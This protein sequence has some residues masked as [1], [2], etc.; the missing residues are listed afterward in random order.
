MLLADGMA[1]VAEQN[2]GTTPVS[3]RCCRAFYHC[4]YR[5]SF[6][7]LNLRTTLKTKTHR[8]R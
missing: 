1:R 4:V 3:P 6:A 2:T 8:K 7:A 5:D